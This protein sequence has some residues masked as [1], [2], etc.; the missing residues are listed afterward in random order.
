VSYDDADLERLHAF[1]RMLLPRLQG[2]AGGDEAL[3]QSVRLAG[4]KV[5]N[6]QKHKLSLDTGQAPDGQVKF[7]HPWP[8]QIPP[9]KTAEL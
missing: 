8:P 6:E 1:C 9:G 4:Y 5:V 7:P 2:Q 3:D